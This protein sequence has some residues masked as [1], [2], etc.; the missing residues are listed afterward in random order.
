VPF[1]V[2]VLQFANSSTE[3]GYYGAAQRIGTVL[4]LISTVFSNSAFPGLSRGCRGPN[5]ERVIG[6]AMRLLFAVVSPIGVGGILLAGPIIRA[7][8]P[9]EFTHAVSMLAILF[10]A[11][12]AMAISDLLR[13]ILAARHHQKLEL[14]L[15]TVATAISICATLP[16]A[17]RYGG[18]GAA[19]AMLIGEV[20]LVA[21]S[22]WGVT[23]TGPGVSILRESYRP[24]AGATLMGAIVA[25]A[26]SVPLLPRIAIG[27]LVYLLWLWLII[28]HLRDDLKRIND[29]R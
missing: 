29:G 2:V 12:T 7:I 13:R 14:K 11:Y 3:V 10:A 8:F 24:L 9:A 4:V 5:Q 25:L 23:R 27:A 19:I 21:L 28:G 17:V 16:L 6:A 20:A 26:T 15:T 18:T 22:L 1:A